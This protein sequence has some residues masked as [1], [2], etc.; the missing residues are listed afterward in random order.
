MRT[1]KETYVANVRFLL[2]NLLKVPLPDFRGNGFTNGTKNTQVFHLV[3]DV[4]VTSTLEQT[5]GS[6]GNVELSDLVLVDH[7]PVAGEVGVGRGTLENNGGA[8]Q[9]QRSIDDVG[10]TSDPA[11]ITTAEEAVIVV[12]VK[13]IL[14]GHGSTQEVTGGGVHDT[15]GLSGG[16]GGVKQEQR[17]FRVDGLGRQVVGVLLDLLV[18]PEVTAGGPGD[19]S[20]GTLVDK[21]AGD[22]RALLQS[23]VDNTLSTNDLATTAALVSGDDDLGASV[24]H[25]IAQRVGGETG[26]DDG[27]NSTDTGDGEEG[28]ERLGNHRKVDGNSVTLLDTLLLQ[29]PGDTGDLTQEF[30]VGDGAALIGL[31]GLVDDGDLVGVLDGVTVDTVEGGVQTALNEPSNVTVLERTIAGGLE[32]LVEGEEV[33]GH[34]GPESVGVANGLIV[35]LPVLVEVFEVSACGVLLVEGLGDVEGV[36]IVSLGDLMQQL[37]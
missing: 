5:Q 14:S 1:R 8:S 20:T 6:G 29:S 25:T 32:V 10:V 37:G 13:D 12:D 17:V 28:N 11:D 22:I 21:H 31:I 36:D 33:P 18:P 19:L 7:V 26:E 4:V 30:T 3:V 34:A 23:F 9:E 15:L 2:A 35:Q 24:Q 27:M 16:T